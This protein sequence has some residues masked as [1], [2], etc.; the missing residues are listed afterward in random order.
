MKRRFKNLICILVGLGLF[1][2]GTASALAGQV[3]ELTEPQGLE[4]CFQILIDQGKS[5]CSGALSA[6]GDLDGERVIDSDS[7][8]NSAHN[9]KPALGRQILA[10]GCRRLVH[11]GIP[12]LK[13]I[14][15]VTRGILVSVNSEPERPHSTQ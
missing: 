8:H 5:Y 11:R 14:A 2:A 3:K 6:M 9:K 10:N 1:S 12:I 7:P 15:M 4:I 13:F